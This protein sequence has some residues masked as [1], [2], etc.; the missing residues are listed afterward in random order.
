MSKLYGVPDV[1]EPKS[2]LDRM[3]YQ[4]ELQ[5][6]M[7]KEAADLAE[8]ERKAAAAAARKAKILS[9]T[10]ALARIPVIGP[11]IAGGSMGYDLADAIERGEKG[12]YSGAAIKGLGA[13]GSGM[14]LIPHPLTRAIGTGLGLAAV[15]AGALNDYLKDIE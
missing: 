13:L 3:I 1:G 11:A 7:S 8:A 2:I 12:D 9:R 14:A 5:E 15:P 4:K 10:G 6:R